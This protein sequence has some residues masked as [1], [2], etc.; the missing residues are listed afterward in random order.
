LHFSA[1]MNLHVGTPFVPA[2]AGRYLTFRAAGEEFA[3]GV[4]VVREIL[5]CERITQFPGAPYWV[6][7]LINLKGSVVPVIDPA[8]RIGQVAASPKAAVCIVITEIASAGK[9]VVVGLAVDAVGEVIDVPDE[10]VRPLPPF[11]TGLRGMAHVGDRLVL[12]LDVNRLFS[13][14][15]LGAM[16]RERKGTA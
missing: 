12:L 6:R 16:L 15:E 14:A 9:T 4:V 5:Q 11:A 13:A 10:R 3:V 2:T 7:G 1:A 8:A